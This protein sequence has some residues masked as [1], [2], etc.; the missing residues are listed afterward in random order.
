MDKPAV[1]YDKIVLV[2]PHLSEL[3]PTFSL[4]SERI[5]RLAKELSIN[6]DMYGTNAT[7]ERFQKV[8]VAN[9]LDFSAKLIE[10]ETTEDFFL[11]HTKSINNIVV[12]CSSRVGSVSYEPLIESLAQKIE[13]ACPNN[14]SIFIYPGIEAENYYSSYQDISANP[15]SAGVETFQKISREVGNIFKKSDIETDE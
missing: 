8:G 5:I 4:W 14:D 15:I 11:L 13:K 9:K 3:E 6:I 2:T 1:S 12:F 7:F 10:I